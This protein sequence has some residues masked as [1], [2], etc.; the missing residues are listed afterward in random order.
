MAAISEKGQG[1]IR[2][3]QCIDSWLPRT[4]NWVYNHTALYPDSV[5]SHVVC[6][7]SQNLHEFPVERL[8]SVEKPPADPTVLRKLLFR[9][10][11]QED[12]KRHLPLLEETLTR[13]QPA[14]LHSHFGHIGSLNA[15]VAKRCRVPHIVSFYGLDVGYLPRVQRRWLSRYRGM[16]KTVAMVLCEGPHMAQR[17]AGLGIPLEKITIFRL[18][19]DLRQIPFTP[20]NFPRD[21]KIRF[22]V[23]GTFREKKG[24]PYAI[25]ALGLLAKEYPNFELTLIGDAGT[26]DREQREKETILRALDRTCLRGRTRLLGYQP[27]DVLIDELYNHHIF[28]SPSVTASDG[29]TEGGA[30]VMLIEAAASGMPVVGTSHCDIPFVLAKENQPFLAPER[31]AQTLVRMI[32]ALLDIKSWKS[33]VSSNR[34]L[35]ESELDCQTQAHKLQELYRQVAGM[36]GFTDGNGIN[37]RA[38]VPVA[39]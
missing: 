34:R 5:E 35:V 16:G 25:E 10:H 17:I 13:I 27:H 12:T 22:L 39:V 33:I 7:W 26:S 21:G 37:A 15:P 29:D 6:Q 31:D 9:L 11:L 1:K 30:P 24:I 23:A 8:Y 2:V 32:R 19:I 3:L 36:R 4:E 18:G 38:D 20:R 28:L 14:V